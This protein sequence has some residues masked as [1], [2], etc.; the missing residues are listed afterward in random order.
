MPH[1]IYTMNTNKKWW[2]INVEWAFGGLE[3]VDQFETEQEADDM[4]LEYGIAYGDS[5]SK[6]WIG[7]K[8]IE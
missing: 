4:L 2:Y 8:E 7:T 5:C 6:I 1:G 3:T